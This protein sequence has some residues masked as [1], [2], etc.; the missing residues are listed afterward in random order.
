MSKVDIN[1]GIRTEIITYRLNPRSALFVRQVSNLSIPKACLNHESNQLRSHSPFPEWLSERS[2]PADG[3]F[4]IT[5]LAVGVTSVIH[6]FE[7]KEH[8]FNKQ[9]KHQIR[10]WFNGRTY[11]QRQKFCICRHF[12]QEIKRHQWS[13]ALPRDKRP[14]INTYYR[15]RRVGFSQ[16]E[17]LLC[18]LTP[19]SILAVLKITLFG[20]FFPHYTFLHMKQLCKS[21]NF[22]FMSLALRKEVLHDLLLEFRLACFGA[23]RQTFQ[24]I[25]V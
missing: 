20:L 13:S 12:S 19:S 4:C 17:P 2:L 5:R 6:I 16:D 7:N 25:R 14:R 9:G 22:I 21:R 1:R 24:R 18:L 3:P 10:V 11:I 8:I 23:H 15:S